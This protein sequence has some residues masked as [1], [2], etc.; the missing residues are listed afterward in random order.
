MFRALKNRDFRRS[1][2]LCAFPRGAPEVACPEERIHLLP[3]TSKEDPMPKKRYTPEQIAAGL[4][5][6]DVALAQGQSIAQAVRRR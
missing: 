2:R 1:S 3:E 5:Q 6:V 4:R